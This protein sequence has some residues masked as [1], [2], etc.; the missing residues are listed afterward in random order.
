MDH[1]PISRLTLFLIVLITCLGFLLR[2]ANLTNTPQGLSQDETAIGYNAFSI[3]QTGKDEHGVSYPLY[4]KSFGDYKLPVYIYL[5]SFTQ[6][7][8][9]VN[10]FSVRAPSAF[11][12]S[13]TVLIIILLIYAI[14]KNSYVSVASGFLLSITPWHI[15]FSRSAFEVNVALFFAVLG[16]YLLVK[17]I[18]NKRFV[19][20]LLLSSSLAYVLSL[21]S[22]NVTRLLIPLLVLFLI[23]TYRKE[24]I[25]ISKKTLIL[26]VIF[27]IVILLPFVS[28]IF[29]KF[30]A[31]SASQ[32]LIFGSNA[33]ANISEFRGNI[34]EMPEIIKII[35][36]N[37]WI[38][39]IWGYVLNLTSYFSAQ[40]LFL[41]GTAHGNQGIGNYG[42]L[43]AFELP[44]LIIGLYTFFKNKL[45]DFA[46]ILLWLIASLIVAGLSYETPHATR[47]YF[48]VIPLT[49]FAALGLVEIV[50]FLSRKTNLAK[51]ALFI[52]AALLT[53][54]SMVFYLSSYYFRFPQV[55][56]KAW[57]EQDKTLTY[58][59]ISNLHKYEK[60]IIDSDSG[61][62][63]T[64]FLFYSEY[65]PEMY[66]TTAR[67]QTDNKIGYI[68]VKSFDKI[69]FTKI[70][71][72]SVTSSG[73][74]LFV[75][76]DNIPP[77]GRKLI[78]DFYYPKRVV[79]FS[80]NGDIVQL[81]VTDIAYRLYE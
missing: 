24:V 44:L 37:K 41:N 6:K 63:Y 14:S 36:F 61:Y 51:G 21:Y 10:E 48:L 32:V 68:T 71:W 29:T 62:M 59:L 80:N 22:Y 46:V 25:K 23:Y 60:V 42:M 52:V 7:I 73:K 39:S 18:K 17:A 72:D 77:V 35:F 15:H 30:G 12:G 28:T 74:T 38:M 26:V 66:H 27:S 53:I 64:S 75:T 20:P 31:S 78:S 45:N 3:N 34:I 40:F 70:D 4:F 5:V 49:V 81:S 43:H 76:Q 65:P 56:A 33:F 16:T 55:Y 8:F 47:G 11:L 57:R 50:T 19:L 9:G 67:Y 2:F 58:Y 13:L 1:K 69:S 79:A 54:Y